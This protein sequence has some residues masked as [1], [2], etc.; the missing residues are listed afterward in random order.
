M[1]ILSAADKLR[2]TTSSNAEVDYSASAVDLTTSS[3]LGAIV[4]GQNAGA[5]T[6]DVIGSPASGVSRQIND[7]SIVNIDPTDPVDITMLI[8]TIKIFP[9]V[10][11]A[12]GEA[13]IYLRGLGW[14]LY[15]ADGKRK[16]D[17]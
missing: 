2:M 9:T 3:F 12:A 17:S 5:G 14:T 8:N 1:I 13:L 15:N 10:T 16:A 6:F 4:R 7:V 11:L